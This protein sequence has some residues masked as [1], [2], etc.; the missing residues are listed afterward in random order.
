MLLVKVKAE[1]AG[2]AKKKIV[3]TLSNRSKRKF[4]TTVANLDSHDVNLKDAV[5]LFKKKLACGCSITETATG[6]NEI[7]IQGDKIDEVLDIIESNYKI[8][9]DS[10][11]VVRG[12]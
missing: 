12:K 3:I 6:E 4:V 8:P 2:A 11:T 9:K 10:V 5:T 7:D 1:K